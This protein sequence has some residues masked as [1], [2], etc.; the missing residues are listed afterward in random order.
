MLISK[1]PPALP[2]SLLK[3]YPLFHETSTTTHVTRQCSR[4]KIATHIPIE[5]PSQQPSPPLKSDPIIIVGAGIFGLSTGLHLA[6]RGYIDVTVF[7]KQ[8]YDRTLYSYFNGC[9]A[10]SA[11]INKIIRCGYGSQTVY[12]SLA[13]ESLKEWNLWNEELASGRTMPPGMTTGDALFVNNGELSITE[14]EELPEF[15]RQSIAELAKAG[16]GRTQLVTG[17]QESEAIAREHGWELAMDPFQRRGK[18]KAYSAVLDTTGGMANADK[19]CRFALHKARHLGVKFVLDPEAG[20]LKSL[21]RLPGEEDTVGGITTGDG[22]THHA[23][24]TILACG[25]WTP[26]LLPTMDGLCEAT[27]GSV[28]MLKIPKG[29]TLWDRFDPKLFPT[30]AWNMRNGAEGGLYG[31]PRDENGWLKI[32]Y[33]GLKYTNPVDQG[34]GIAR[35]VPVTRWTEN[36]QLEGLP[37]QASRVISRFLREYLPE[38]AAEGIHIS[39]TRLCWYTDSFDNHLVIDRVPETSGLMVATG[40]SGHAFKYLPSLGSRVVDIIEG[41]GCDRPDVQAWR[42]RAKVD[43]AQVTNVLME[44]TKSTRALQ[45]VSLVSISDI[46]VGVV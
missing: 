28:V 21:Y 18:G 27:A 37:R 34:D 11:D 16:Y 25:G 9:D 29:S 36:D 30:W 24:L 15:E 13:L 35:S 39:T 31:F 20:M 46:T 5:M 38:L 41:V 43:G 1:S 26:M 45:N 40:G 19:A 17:D 23:A 10:A 7:D 12:Q 22:K 8:P 3:V 42:W 44:G 32:G 2:L 4:T 6:R 14:A 33:R